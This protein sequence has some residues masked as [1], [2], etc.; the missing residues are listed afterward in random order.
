MGLASLAIVLAIVVAVLALW[1][2][3]GSKR[4]RLKRDVQIRLGCE[5]VRGQGGILV[6][7][8]SFRDSRTGR[9]VFDALQKATCPWRVTL[10]VYEER[11]PEDAYALDTYLR[12][13]GSHAARDFRDRVR[14]R[15]LGDAERTS[16]GVL[17]SIK[18]A[19]SQLAQEERFVLVTEPGVTFAPRWDEVLVSEW[20]KARREMHLSDPVVSHPAASTPKLPEGVVETMITAASSSATAQPSFPVYLSFDHAAPRVGA[21]LFP[22]GEREIPTR[23]IAACA[24]NAFMET[25]LLRRAAEQSAIFSSPMARYAADAALSSALWK[26]G[27]GSSLPPRLLRGPLAPTRRRRDFDPKDGGAACSSTPSTRALQASIARRSSLRGE[28]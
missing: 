13:V 27:V 20:Q 11:E 22:H 10:A 19:L 6:L 28:R 17:G 25:S 23:A 7:V 2:F 12:L 9:T 14:V 3:L 1:N 8:P 26:A 18:E 15:S 4:R 21:M 24:E 5:R 16:V